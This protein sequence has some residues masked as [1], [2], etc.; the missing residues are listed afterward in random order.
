MREDARLLVIEHVLPE[1]MDLADPLTP[2]QVH[3]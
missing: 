3:P 1:R 2:G